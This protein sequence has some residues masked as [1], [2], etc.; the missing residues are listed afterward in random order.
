MTSG[1]AG[2]DV[3]TVSVV[4]PTRND[5]KVLETCLQLLF[6][7]TRPADEIIVVDNG[8]SD[9]TASVC[10]AAGVRRIAVN[11]P[12]IPAT[13]A[14][15]FD[16]AAGDTIA[17]LDTD[18]RP[19]ADWLERVEGVL[20]AADPMSLVTGPAQFYGGPPW[21]RWAGKHLVLNGYF[22]VFGILLGHPP[23]FGSNFALSRAVWEE[24][25]GSVVRN[26]ADVHDDLDIS[27]R[28]RPEMKVIYDRTLSVGVSSRPLTSWAS[29]R[30]HASMTLTTFRVEFK[31]EPPLRRRLDRLRARRRRV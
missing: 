31:E 18:S 9:D 7:Q 8:S 25:G 27:Y 3:R 24:I 17:R 22:K 26:N 15:G 2:A 23:V 20:A 5:A 13:A 12:G 28:L 10:S 21:V 1:D 29:L 6:R 16:A 30:R 11:L 19:P 4:I 14:A